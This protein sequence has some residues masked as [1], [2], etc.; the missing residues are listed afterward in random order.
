MTAITDRQTLVS[1]FNAYIK[2]QFATDRSDTFLQLAHDRIFRDLRPRET[3]LQVQ[4]TPTTTLIDLPTDF[5]DMRQLSYLKNNR[6]VTLRSVGRH[7]LGLF[8]QNQDQASDTRVYSVIGTQIE[9]APA[10]ANREY[11]LWYWQK[12]PQLIADDDTNIILDNY[13]YLY[14]YGMLIEGNVY[15][16]DSEQRAASLETYIGEMQQVN[17]AADR[18]RFGEAPVLGAA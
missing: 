1:E 9:V 4:I 3:M 6:R 2:R 15:I 12:L 17:G 7:E 18:S 14:L 8:V 11:T 5:V 10:G 13:P 16:Q